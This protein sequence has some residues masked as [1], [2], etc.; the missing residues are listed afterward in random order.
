MPK[1]TAAVPTYGPV[2]D[3]CK[4]KVHSMAFGRVLLQ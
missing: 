4:G 2:K 3:A 1:S